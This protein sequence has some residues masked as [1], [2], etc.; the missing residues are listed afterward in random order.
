VQWHNFGPAAPRHNLARRTRAAPPETLRF[1]MHV[2]TPRRLRVSPATC[3]APPRRSAAPPVPAGPPRAS[4]L[5][6]RRPML[7]AIPR[8]KAGY[9][10]AQGRCH[11][12][13]FPRAIKW[14]TRPSRTWAPPG[15]PPPCSP[16]C[17]SESPASKLAP[18]RYPQPCDLPDPP[19]ARARAS[20][21][22]AGAGRRRQPPR[23]S[24]P[25][26]FFGLNSIL[27]ELTHLLH[28]S[29]DRERRRNRWIPASPRRPLVQGPNCVSLLLL[30]E[31]CVNWGHI[32]GVLESSRGL[33]ES[34]ILK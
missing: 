21:L 6:A 29:P 25:A 13:A 5:R 1:P 30:R 20:G 31:F 27:G 33:C 28:P 8:L 15:L 3:H 2:H 12:P 16:P 24:H 17:A 19:L 18:S 10:F 32:Y 14:P 7:L 9:S 22:A 26:P 34:W 11:S 23:H 4:G